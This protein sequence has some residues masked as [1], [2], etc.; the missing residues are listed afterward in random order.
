M[1]A[2]LTKRVCYCPVCK[3]SMAIDLQAAEYMVVMCANPHCPDQQK[4]YKQKLEYTDL[5]QISN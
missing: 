3:V 2:E 4:R 5:E 1:R